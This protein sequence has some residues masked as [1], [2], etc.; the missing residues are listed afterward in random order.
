MNR[1]VMSETTLP[2]ILSKYVRKDERGK[3][4]FDFEKIAPVGD[5]PDW[6]DRRIEQWG[7]K[8]I[9]YDVCIGDS[10]IDFCTA[11]TPPVPVIKKLAELHKELVFTLEYAEPGMMF[12]GRAVAKWQGNTV[13]LD[14]NCWDMTERDLEELG[15]TG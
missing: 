10:A 15:L 4:V 12:R 7:T 8:W 11:W 2:V 9:G 13:R 1:L 6:L 5:T 3:N 14:D